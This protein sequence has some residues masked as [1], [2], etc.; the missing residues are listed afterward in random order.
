MIFVSAGQRHDQLYFRRS[1]TFSNFFPTSLEWSSS[2]RKS[3]GHGPKPLSSRIKAVGSTGLPHPG[4]KR[5]GAGTGMCARRARTRVRAGMQAMLLIFQVSSASVSAS[6][7]RNM[8][9]LLEN[10][11][12]QVKYWLRWTFKIKTCVDLVKRRKSKARVVVPGK[13]QNRLGTSSGPLTAMS[14]FFNPRVGNNVV[15]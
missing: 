15:I 10:S 11:R 8:V 9:P 5:S 1:N 2:T 7:M 12:C 6:S 3:P 14:D 13:H 4:A